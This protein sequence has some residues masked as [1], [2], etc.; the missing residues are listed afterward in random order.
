MKKISGLI[1]HYDYKKLFLTIMKRHNLFDI[2]IL[3]SDR[4]KKY[5]KNII[6]D[7]MIRGEKAK[8]CICRSL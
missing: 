6:D 3:Q 2:S 1:S 7:Y 5:L 4:N 8:I